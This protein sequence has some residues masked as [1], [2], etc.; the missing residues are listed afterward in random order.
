MLMA[1][2]GLEAQNQND[3]AVISEVKVYD[4]GNSAGMIEER[5]SGNRRLLTFN[6]TVV[7]TGDRIPSGTV[8]VGISESIR[9]FCP[10]N[11]KE[12]GIIISMAIRKLPFVVE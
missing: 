7:V 12:M 9:A 10:S 4:L 11:H 1:T 2:L 6:G 8:T 3:N 5:A